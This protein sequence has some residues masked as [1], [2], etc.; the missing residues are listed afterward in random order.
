MAVPGPV[1]CLA[2]IGVG[3]LARVRPNYRD[4]MTLLAQTRQG[5]LNAT[6][7]FLILFW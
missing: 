7:L 1:R 5:A 6:P 3:G 2:V 4:L